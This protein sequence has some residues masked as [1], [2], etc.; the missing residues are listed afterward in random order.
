[1]NSAEDKTRNTHI[2]HASWHPVSG[3]IPQEAP[4]LHPRPH[5]RQNFTIC[6]STLSASCITTTIDRTPI[7]ITATHTS[8]LATGNTDSKTT[9]RHLSHLA[10]GGITPK[11]VE[12]GI[13]PGP[14]YSQSST[15]CTT[16]NPNLESA[17]PVSRSRRKPYRTP[18]TRQDSPFKRAT[19]THIYLIQLS[20][21]PSLP[22]AAQ[23]IRPALTWDSVDYPEETTSSDRVLQCYRIR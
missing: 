3:R 22:N 19:P 6:P 20:H 5:L 11:L 1:M 7:C 14:I 16:H 2:L 18:S 21:L 13:S 10:L 8:R 9:Y 15:G 17:G 12:K 23:H 4:L